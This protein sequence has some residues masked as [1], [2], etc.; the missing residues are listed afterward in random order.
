MTH[1]LTFVAAR[2]GPSDRPF[3]PKYSLGSRGPNSP[4]EA[5]S[6]RGTSGARLWK[7]GTRCSADSEPRRGL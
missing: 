7:A 1:N 6:K 4:S 3:C 5:P 2:L